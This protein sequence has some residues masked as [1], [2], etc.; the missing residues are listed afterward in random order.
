MP[1]LLY[2]ITHPNVEIN[3]QI[4]ITDWPLS[5]TGRIRMLACLK[6]PWISDITAIYSSTEQKA[7]DGATIIAKHL[8]LTF[9]QIT[10]LGEIDRSTTGFLPLQEFEQT[11]D[12]FFSH[13]ET[14]TRGWERA[15]DAQLRITKAITQLFNNDKTNGSIAIVSH[16][17]VGALLYCELTKNKISRQ[18]DQPANEGG[19]YFCFTLHPREVLH[20]WRSID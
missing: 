6:Q 12:I 2:F 5:G 1:R 9:T 17:A 20:H 7:V 19:N 18:W 4:P 15:I 11:A 10:E 8:S 14:S 3:K 16:G 13:P